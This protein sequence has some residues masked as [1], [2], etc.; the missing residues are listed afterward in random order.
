MSKRW[1][2][3]ILTTITGLLFVLVEAFLLCANGGPAAL[4]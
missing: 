1:F 2:Q 4:E 3:I